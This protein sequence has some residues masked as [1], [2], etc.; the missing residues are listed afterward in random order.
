M[1]M[2]THLKVLPLGAYDLLLGMDW[3]YLHWTKVDYYEKEIKCLDE[4]GRKK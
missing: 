3:L 1:D 4:K 2:V